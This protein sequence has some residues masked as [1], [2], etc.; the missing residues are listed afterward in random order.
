[1]EEVGSRVGGWEDEQTD[2]E[3]RQMP[4]M[5]LKT[6]GSRSADDMWRPK[7]IRT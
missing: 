5:V 2:A 6:E 7:E 1:M 4:W 3:E